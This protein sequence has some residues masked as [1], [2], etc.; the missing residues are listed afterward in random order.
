[1]FAP[2]VGG[3]VNLTSEHARLQPCG[4]VHLFS[5]ISA[6]I[7]SG[8]QAN[9]A[10]ANA[11]LDAMASDLHAKVWHAANLHLNGLFRHPHIA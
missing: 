1:M 9:Y 10:S 3:A 2:K 4:A 6:Q 5:S 8:G 7:G 11:A